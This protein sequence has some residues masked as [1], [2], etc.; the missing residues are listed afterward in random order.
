MSENNKEKRLKFYPIPIALEK[1]SVILEQ[2]KKCICKIIYK[3]GF[4]TGFFC[5][6]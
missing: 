2:M 4:G 1:T 5:N 3:N 6:I